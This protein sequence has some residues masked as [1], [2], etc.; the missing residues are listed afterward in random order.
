M[1][2]GELGC[3]RDVTDTPIFVR[4][5][6]LMVSA[7]DGIMNKVVGFGL[8]DCLCSLIVWMYACRY[9]GYAFTLLFYCN[10]RCTFC[11]I[12]VVDH[13][14]DGQIIMRGTDK[15]KSEWEVPSVFACL[16][17]ICLFVCMHIFY[18]IL[19]LHDHCTFCMVGVGRWWNDAGDGQII[20]RG[21]DKC[22]FDWEVP[23]VFCCLASI[24]FACIYVNI[25]CI[26]TS[27]LL[28]C[29]LCV[30]HCRCRGWWENAGDGHL[31]I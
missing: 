10:L 12:G 8:R 17:C 29:T 14:G 24:L 19:H 9:V 15:C 2:G 25:S 23:S 1:R 6:G 21:T 4:S 22:K 16:A 18:Y 5:C 30:L 31:Q 11:I 3:N 13:A 27:I 7:G 28:H 20:M 26:Y